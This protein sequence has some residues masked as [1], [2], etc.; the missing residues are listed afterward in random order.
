MRPAEDGQKHARSKSR[1]SHLLDLQMH[2][3]RSHQSCPLPAH[4]RPEAEPFKSSF[5]GPQQIHPIRISNQLVHVLVL[6]CEKSVKTVFA[7]C[8]LARSDYNVT[9]SWQTSLTSTISAT[10]KPPRDQDRLI[11]V[12]WE[13]PSRPQRWIKLHVQC[14]LAFWKVENIISECLVF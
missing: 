13:T 9:R 4:P 5:A 1:E 3:G 6:T 14:S 7:A 10:L 12:F 2:G 11:D 8:G